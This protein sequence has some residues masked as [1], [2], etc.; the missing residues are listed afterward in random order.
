MESAEFVTVFNQFG[1]AFAAELGHGDQIVGVA[2]VEVDLDDL[3]QGFLPLRF[4]GWE[5]VG[6]A[7]CP[8]RVGLLTYGGKRV[9]QVLLL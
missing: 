7:S 5:S 6:T 9:F 1:G 2:A 8:A 3:V 4:E